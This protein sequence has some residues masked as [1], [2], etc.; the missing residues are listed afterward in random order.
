MGKINDTEHNKGSKIYPHYQV[1]LDCIISSIPLKH[2]CLSI[3]LIWGK[4][5]IFFIFLLCL[6]GKK[7]MVLGKKVA[8]FDW[9]WGQNLA[10]EK[11]R[12]S[13]VGTEA[14]HMAIPRK[15]EEDFISH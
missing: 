12:K 1:I 13:P 2:K 8:I 11:G 6:I 5:F 10:L 9:E 4:I 14:N 7:D 15:M 3:I